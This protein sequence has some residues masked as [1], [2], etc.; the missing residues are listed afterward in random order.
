MVEKGPVA[1]PENATP[2]APG[3]RGE[4]N[5]HIVYMYIVLLMVPQVPSVQRCKI[6]N[7][8]YK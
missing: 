6:E 1:A 4:K 8:Q 7:T 5:K 3:N 2:P